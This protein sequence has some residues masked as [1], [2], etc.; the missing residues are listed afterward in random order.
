LEF[1]NLKFNN[2]VKLEDEFLKIRRVDQKSGKIQDYNFSGDQIKTKLIHKY[3]T[4]DKVFVSL[5]K[6][7]SLIWIPGY[8]G[9]TLA[10]KKRIQQFVF[11]SFFD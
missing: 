4:L 9:I 5:E 7:D 8:Y 10:F 3:N 2:E 11:S 6:N 1:K